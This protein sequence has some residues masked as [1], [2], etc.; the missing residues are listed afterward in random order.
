MKNLQTRFE[1]KITFNEMKMQLFG[2]T[3]IHN[4]TLLLV[5]YSTAF[6]LH[7]NTCDR[8]SYAHDKRELFV[9][10]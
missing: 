4:G 1:I 7:K 10:Q 8:Y 3:S 9:N 5:C 6:R 2:Y